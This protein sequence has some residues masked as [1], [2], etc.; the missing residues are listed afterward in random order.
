MC[1]FISG[2]S[3]LIHCSICFCASL[4]HIVL[5][6]LALQYSLKS[7]SL[8]PQAL[9]FLKKIS[10]AILGLL[11]FHTNYRTILSVKIIMG[12]LIEIALNLYIAL[13]I[14]NISTINRR[15]L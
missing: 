4:C 1:G 13:G 11:W 5:I 3:F 14:R 9:C 2:L 15:N 12:I 10:L 8:T 6:T 7:R